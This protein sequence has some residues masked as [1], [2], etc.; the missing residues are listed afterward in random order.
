MQDWGWT[1]YPRLIYGIWSSKFFLETPVSV[2]KN[3]ETRT[4]TQ[5]VSTRRKLPMRMKF[6]GMI[7]DL[8]N[9]HFISS[10]VHSS[11]KEVL[12]YIFEDNE[13]VIKMIIKGRSPT[14]RHVSRTHRVA[15]D[16]LSD[17]IKLD[18]KIQIKYIATKNQLVDTLTKGNFTRDEWNHLL[19]LFD[20]SHFRSINCLEAMSKRTKED[21][22]EERVTAKSKPMMNLVSRYSVM[23]PNVLAPI[24]SESS[25]K[26]RSESQKVLVSSLNEQLTGT[27]KPVT[28]ASSSNFSEW[29]NDDKW[30]S[31]V[32]KSGEMSKTS[33]VKPVDDKF[34]IDY[35][36]DSDTFTESNLSLKSRSFL[37]RV[38]DRLRKRLDHY[39]KD[40]IHGKEL[41]KQFTFHQKHRERSHFK[42][43]VWR[44]WKVDNRTFRW[45]FWSVSNQLGRF[46]METIIFGQWRVSRMQMFLY[47]QIL[48]YVLERW[49]RTHYQILFGNDS[50]VGSKIHHNTELWTQSMEN[51]WNSSGIFSR[52]LNI[53]A[54]PRSPTSSW[55]HWAIPNNAKDE[56]STCRCLMTWYGELQTMNMNVSLTPDLCL[57]LQE[58]FL[59]DV[60]HSSNQDQKRS[61]ILFTS[62]DHEKNGIESLNWWWSKFGESGHPVFRAT[63]PLSRGTLKSKGG[64]NSSIL[65]CADG[66]TFGTVF[67]TIISVNR[68]SIFGA[69]SDLCEEHSACQTITWRPVLAGQSD[70]L[71]EPAKL[72]ITTPT[73]SIAI[74]AQEN[75][76]QKSTRNEWKDRLIKICTDAGFLK[77]VEVGQYFMTKHTDEFSQFTEP[78]TCREYTLPRDEKSTD[79]KGWVRGSTKIEPVLEVTSSYLQGEYG[80]EIRMNLWRKT[81]LTRWSEFLMDWISWSQTW[82]T[83]EYE[84]NEQE[85]SE[86]KTEVFALKT[87]VFAFASLSNAKAKLRRPSTTCSSPRTV[88]IFRRILIL[89]QELNPIRR[90]QWQKDWTLFFGIDNYIEKKMVRLNSEDQKN[91]FGTNLSTINIGL[92]MCGRARWQEAE[93]TRK[94]FITVLTRQD[95]KIFTSELF[96]VIQD[97]QSHWSYTSGQCINFGQLLRVH[98]S[99]WMCRVSLHS[100]TNSRLIAGVQIILAGKDR[101]Y[102]LRLW[103]PWTRNTKIRKSLIWP[104][105]VLNR[106]SRKKWKRHRVRCIGSICSLLNEKDL[107]SIKQDVMQSYFTTHSQLIVSESCC[108]GIWRNHVRESIC[109]TSTTTENF[110]QR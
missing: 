26:T 64:G 14:M 21:A 106:T 13:A 60:G 52:I 93:A 72:L 50:W 11:C 65:F 19:C 51:R 3:G 82:S 97:T 96:K 45:D 110:L 108:D 84:D 34:V 2:I 91:M 9:V 36:M 37:N 98:L 1:V 55:T 66:D 67:R 39:S 81:I 101:E 27:V 25:G 46:S 80:V 12:L 29:N 102:S 28:H 20:I 85:T 77:T 61:G 94:D 104:N 24:A 75:F 7:D 95:K 58:D 6:H 70:P 92:M 71:F 32:R 90:T 100:F 83:K 5:F 17:R 86:P 99:Y 31:H 89:N 8:D 23:E 53:G 88:L 18:H 74:L 79:P 47:F 107:S 33:L 76:L 63:S 38:N 22:G 16:S 43:D 15:L 54:C 87:E 49:I 59:Q 48:C 69:V 42:T 62:I 30:S 56:S 41:L 109:V 105:H 68:L 40:A 4:R 103:I 10:N 57:Y 73:P 44:I 35:D 78:V